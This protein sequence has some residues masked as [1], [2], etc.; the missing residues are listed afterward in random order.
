MSCVT[1]ASLGRKPI[2]CRRQ[3]QASSEPADLSA[4]LRGPSSLSPLGVSAPGEGSE[5]K[6]LSSVDE[7]VAL[8]TTALRDG[9]EEAALPLVTA[10]AQT[11]PAEATI[12]QVLGLL[13]R[14]LDDLEPA[15]AAFETGGA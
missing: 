7:I 1:G 12:W 14:A 15:M 9:T 2:R 5:E 3:P 6:T 13:Y 4:A 8:A 11:H 10:A